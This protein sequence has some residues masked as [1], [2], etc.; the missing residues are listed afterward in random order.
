MLAVGREPDPVETELKLSANGPGALRRLAALHALAGTQLGTAETYLELDRYLDTADHR[1]ATAKWACRLRS[2]SRE[3]RISLKGPPVAPNELGG[4]LHSRPEVEGPASAELDP[5]SWP[6]SAARER[7]LELIAGAP[8]EEQFSLQQARTQRP[9]GSGTHRLGTLS[10]DRVLVMREGRAA[11]RLWCVELELAGSRVDDAGSG[12]I[13]RL[14]AE[15][16]A[17]GGLSVEPLTKL[18]RALELLGRVK[19]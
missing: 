13:P 17:T 5:D 14:L 6:A 4:A 15:L 2:R 3:Y 10:L 19:T 16:L 1:L 11:G 18:E 8:L 12:L 9:L 7:L